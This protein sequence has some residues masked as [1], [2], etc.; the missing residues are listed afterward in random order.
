MSDISL[1]RT[2][3]EN[4]LVPRSALVDA[5][6]AH[7]E[8]AV[9]GRDG[10][11]AALVF[12]PLS[13]DVDQLLGLLADPEFAQKPLSELCRMAKI[14]LSQ[15]WSLWRSGEVARASALATRSIGTHLPNVVEDVMKRAAPYE[16]TCDACG[17]LGL[18]TPDPTKDQPNPSPERC[19]RCL[20][21]GKLRYEPELDRQVIALKVGGLLKD[22]GGQLVFNQNLAVQNNLGA[23]DAAGALER[24]SEATDQILYGDQAPRAEQTEFVDGTIEDDPADPAAKTGD[25]T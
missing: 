18:V 20:G 21:G 9:G 15:L 12:V 3:T 1:T 19:D 10:L 17:G 2:P 11:S 23:G 13:P 8:K 24:L 5:A 4:K 6:M 25:T 16:D 14:P 22:G 7:L